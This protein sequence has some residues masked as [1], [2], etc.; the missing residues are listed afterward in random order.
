[1]WKRSSLI[2]RRHFSR[3][4]MRSREP[5]LEELSS[6]GFMTILAPNPLPPAHAYKH[7]N[8]HWKG[9]LSWC[10]P[11]DVVG[12]TTNCRHCHYTNFVVIDGTACCYPWHQFLLS[13]LT[14]QVVVHDTNLVAT[15]T[16]VGTCGA[17]IS[18]G[19]VGIMMM[20]LCFSLC[21]RAPV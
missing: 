19:K 5:S 13:L 8:I 4:L 16:G 20:T 3:W 21:S 15:V 17:A 9:E 1:M 10:Q 14:P 11:F 12:D 18:D 7:T 2:I 6:R